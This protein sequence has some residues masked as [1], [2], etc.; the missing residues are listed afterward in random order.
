MIPMVDDI[1][2][3]EELEEEEV[4]VKPY[5]YYLLN[6]GSGENPIVFQG[7]LYRFRPGI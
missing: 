5:D 1:V 3:E 2:E 6:M 4:D 7:E